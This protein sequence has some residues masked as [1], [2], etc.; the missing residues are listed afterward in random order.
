MTEGPYKEGVYI[1]AQVDAKIKKIHEQ[2]KEIESLKR[3]IYDLKRRK[4]VFGFEIFKKR[5]VG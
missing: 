5:K 2:F 4:T 3:E 1:I